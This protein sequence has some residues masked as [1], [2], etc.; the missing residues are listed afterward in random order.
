MAKQRIPRKTKKKLKK[1]LQGNKYFW[2]CFVDKMCFSSVIHLLYH[3]ECDTITSLKCGKI[4]YIFS[5][6]NNTDN[7]R[8]WGE[9]SKKNK[10]QRYENKHQFFS[11]TRG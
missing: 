9:M 5:Y 6:S 3:R 8:F 11:N 10:Q 7:A 4:R 2:F 1:I